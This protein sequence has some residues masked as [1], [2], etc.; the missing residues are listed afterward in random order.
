MLYATEFPSDFEDQAI[1]HEIFLIGLSWMKCAK[2]SVW[3]NEVIQFWEKQQLSVA[4][5]EI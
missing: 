5:L 2:L 3:F 1:R 4:S